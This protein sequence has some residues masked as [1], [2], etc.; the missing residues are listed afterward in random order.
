M[1]IFSDSLFISFLLSDHRCGF[2]TSF[3]WSLTDTLEVFTLLSCFCFL[4]HRFNQPS[5]LTLSPRNADI[6]SI[7][8]SCPLVLPISSTAPLSSLPRLHPLPS[9]AKFLYFSGILDPLSSSPSLI[10]LIKNILLGR[11]LSLSHALSLCLFVCFYHC[12][13]H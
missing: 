7:S 2:L 3:I 11:T 1:S 9:L 5:F 12:C 8:E 6:L 10:H 13:S 4:A